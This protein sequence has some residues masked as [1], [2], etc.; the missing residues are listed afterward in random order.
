[1][2]GEQAEFHRGFVME[3][4]RAEVSVAR[5]RTETFGLSVDSTQLFRRLRNL[6]DERESRP[7]IRDLF[8]VGS[9]NLYRVWAA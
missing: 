9:W 1:M 8:N 7:H 3:H 2:I 5:R 6:V 4:S